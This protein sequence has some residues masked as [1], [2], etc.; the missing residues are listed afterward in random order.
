[1][2]VPRCPNPQHVGSQVV[3]AGW[4]GK[5]PHRRQRWLC[6]PKNGDPPHRFTPTLTRQVHRLAAPHGFCLECSTS[7]EPWNG[8]AGARRYR[9]AAREVGEALR[10]VG[11]GATYRQAAF[12]ARTQA[13]RRRPQ[14]FTVGDLGRQ[15]DSWF[16]GQIVANWVD[17]FTEPLT[18][19]VLPG[20]WP[21]ML[22]IDS[23]EMRVRSGPRRGQSFHVIAA[24]G[25][26]PNPGGWQNPL[27]VWHVEASPTKYAEAFERFCRALE[28]RP[29]VVITDMDSGT[30]AGIAAAFADEHGEVPELRMGEWHMHRSL[31]G[32]IPDS[33]LA[34]T[35][36][37]VMR[38]LGPAFYD[39]ERWRA[40]CEAVEH[41]HAAQTHGPLG[42]LLRWIDDYGAIVERQAA[43]RRDPLLV[44]STSPVEARLEELK[45]RL[46][47]RAGSF[48]NLA[49]MNKLLALMALDLRGEADGRQWADRVRE[50]TYLD[51][52]HAAEQRPHDDP[53]DIVSLTAGERFPDAQN[54]A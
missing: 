5:A 2:E 17:V 31:R 6:R 30:R 15:R 23:T 12:A 25:R 33:M 27:R 18:R 9:F 49:R 1:M 19:G 48:T 35:A 4:Y 46:K 28:G 54:A 37:I 47:D 44:H 40:F 36:S 26:D 29:R 16:D 52:G 14:R 42:L 34:D 8:Q 22:V 32:R 38:R 11:G 7:V 41:E 21:E 43:T 3:R 24:V 45:R 53:V 50:R 39:A 51:G 13:E 10:L 20:T